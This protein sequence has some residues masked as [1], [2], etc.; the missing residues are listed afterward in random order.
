MTR[1]ERQAQAEQAIRQWA[2]YQA[3]G[4]PN[5]R[6]NH[7]LSL[8]SSPR[9]SPHQVPVLIRTLFELV[10]G[11]DDIIASHIQALDIESVLAAL[12]PSSA[13]SSRVSISLNRHNNHC[14]RKGKGKF[15][16]ALDEVLDDDDISALKELHASLVTKI[17]NYLGIITAEQ[18]KIDANLQ[19]SWSAYYQH[20]SRLAINDVA[21]ARRLA[22]MDDESA[23]EF[24]ENSDLAASS[25]VEPP[26][27]MISAAA[28]AHPPGSLLT[29]RQMVD[30][31]LGYLDFPDTTRVTSYQA[32]MTFVMTYE[33][34]SRTNGNVVDPSHNHSKAGGSGAGRQ[35]GENP[36][37][38]QNRGKCDIC[39]N[40]KL[41]WRVGCGHLHCRGCL[42]KLCK[43][44]LTDMTLVP[45]ACCSRAIPM[46]VLQ[47]LLGENEYQLLVIRTEEK[48]A[49]RKT[50]CSNKACQSFINLS[51][52]AASQPTINCSRCGTQA[53]NH[54]GKSAHSGVTCEEF[55]KRTETDNDRRF[56]N[57]VRRAGYKRCRCGHWVELS[58]GCN[59]I[60]CIG[61]RFEFCYICRVEWKGCLCPVWDEERLIA[62]GEQ[63]VAAMNQAQPIA[64]AARAGVLNQVMDHL[65]VNIDECDHHWVRHDLEG[66]QCTHCGFELHHYGYVCVNEFCDAV[67]CRTCRFHRLNHVRR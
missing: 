1:Q 31:I 67:T 37:T 58:L 54:C 29:V 42:T 26:F 43:L 12:T 60:T 8:F 2:S 3:L 48:M 17:N 34:G 32:A 56:E 23:D 33:G 64:L 63:V 46:T 49:D 35:Q 16:E 39:L 61:C 19:R 41:C 5:T 18:I 51:H 7:L 10:K 27:G 44:S 28:F 40:S 30:A 4:I 53:C 25:S 57:F 15:S 65:R 9:T 11:A 62:R 20:Q 59:H 24:L 13:T 47:Q 6:P 14:S 45:V 55:R 21:F 66:S 52:V 22:G 38:F 50:Y 36:A